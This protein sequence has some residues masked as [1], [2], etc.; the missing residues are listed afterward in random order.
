MSQKI[1]WSSEES[2]RKKKQHVGRLIETF[3]RNRQGIMKNGNYH[4][5][6]ESCYNVVCQVFWKNL[7]FPFGVRCGCVVNRGKSGNF[8]LEW[9]SRRWCG[10]GL[11]LY[12]L[13]IWGILVAELA[14]E[15]LIVIWTISVT[16]HSWS[17]GAPSWL[18]SQH[19]NTW[20]HDILS[21]FN[22]RNSKSITAS[23]FETQN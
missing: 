19:S 16:G 14:K 3:F 15:L 13:S 1:C 23:T 17:T 9:L 21:C 10:G 11:L 7:R 6:Q 4:L 8:V 2:L 18:T 22:I 20:Y 5:E 12:E